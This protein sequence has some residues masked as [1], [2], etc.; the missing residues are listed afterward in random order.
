MVNSVTA[1]YEELHSLSIELDGQ[2][3]SGTY[4]VMSGSV[5]VY[6][7]SEIKFATYGTN[8]PALIAGWLLKDLCRRE[9]MRER[10][11]S[12]T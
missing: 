5:I 8:R 2:S 1:E 3:F 7:G 9:I 10:K 12:G 6:R 4:R 11:Q